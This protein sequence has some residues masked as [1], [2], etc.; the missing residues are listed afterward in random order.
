MRNNTCI[1]QM[2]ET[3]RILISYSIYAGI[4]LKSY[5]FRGH[6]LSQLSDPYISYNSWNWTLKSENNKTYIMT[7]D[8]NTISH[9]IVGM[10]VHLQP[11]HC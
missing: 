2:S 11:F 10:G 5:L 3:R 4:K 1:W 6:P 7:H 8:S 9:I